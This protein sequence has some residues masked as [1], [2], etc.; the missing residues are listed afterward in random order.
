MDPKAFSHLDPKLKAAYDRVM[1]TATKPASPSLDG[2]ALAQ[3]STFTSQPPVNQ[4]PLVPGNQTPPPAFTPPQNSA[5]SASSPFPQATQPSV[6]PLTYQ[7][8]EI[9]QAEKTLSALAQRMSQGGQ[10]PSNSHT[11]STAARH[12]QA[13]KTLPFLL[14]GAGAVFLIAYVIFWMKFFN[15]P[16]PF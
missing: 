6:S 15:L 14:I 13:S 12:Q 11:I 9:P 7:V 3:P 5:F 1:N 10:V 16:L 2:P 4:S 8:N